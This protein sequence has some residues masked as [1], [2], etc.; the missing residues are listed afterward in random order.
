MKG[1]FEDIFHS[2][3]FH[4]E[5]TDVTSEAE[6]IP[7]NFFLCSMWNKRY[8]QK[9]LFIGFSCSTWN[10]TDV[11]FT[12]EFIHNYSTWNNF[13]IREDMVHF[14]RNVP[15]GNFIEKP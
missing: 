10:K 5:Q 3:L 14:Q 11:P 15:R 9:F 6:N 8:R 2:S 1:I 4:V 7:P 12:E 13:G